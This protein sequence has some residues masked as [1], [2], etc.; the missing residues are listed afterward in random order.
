MLPLLLSISE[1]SLSKWMHSNICLRRYCKD[2]FEVT[3]VSDAHTLYSPY[4]TIPAGTCAKKIAHT[5]QFCLVLTTKE[6]ILLLK[7]FYLNKTNK[8]G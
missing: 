5:A 1:E 7:G 4:A 3:D 8:I 6:V 2:E